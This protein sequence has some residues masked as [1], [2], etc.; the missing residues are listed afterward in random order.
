MEDGGSDIVGNDYGTL[1]KKD[2]QN[3]YKCGTIRALY[4]NG[5]L[6]KGNLR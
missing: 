4:V 6:R 3:A 5:N 2:F 1:Y